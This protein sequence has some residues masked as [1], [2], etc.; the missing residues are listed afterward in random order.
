[1]ESSKS[2]KKKSFGILPCLANNQ[3]SFH[4]SN[5]KIDNT[6][7]NQGGPTPSTTWGTNHIPVLATGSR[8]QKKMP[9]GVYRM[10][11]RW[12]FYIIIHHTFHCSIDFGVT[13]SKNS[14]CHAPKLRFAQG[15]TPQKQKRISHWE[16][17][18]NDRLSK[19]KII[20]NQPSFMRYTS[21]DITY[22]PIW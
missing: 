11:I 13:L 10:W 4:Y 2:K 16:K 18:A 6:V 12:Y 21:L 1:M 22:I 19:C 5:P 14:G 9:K 3:F 17:S 7:E 20:I 8:T 15:T